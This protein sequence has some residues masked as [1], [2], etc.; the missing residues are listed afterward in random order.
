MSSESQKP[1]IFERLINPPKVTSHELHSTHV[2]MQQKFTDPTFP[3]NIF[4]L[5]GKSKPAEYRDEW[6]SFVWKRPEE[7]WP[8]QNPQV[9]Y[10]LSPTAVEQGFLGDSYF[11]SALSLLAET[12]QHLTRLLTYKVA[13]RS[14]VYGVWLHLNGRW[15]EVVVDDQFP[16]YC[17]MPPKYK[18]AFSHSTTEE[19]WV[20]LFEKAY[21]KAYGSYYAITGGSLSL[22]LGDLTGAPCEVTRLDR[23]VDVDEIWRSLVNFD[24]NGF[25]FCF[26]NRPAV[27]KDPSKQREFEAGRAFK[28][29]SGTEFQPENKPKMR[30][31]KIR[32][33]WSHKTEIEKVWPE[34][35]IR[36]SDK[37][38]EQFGELV[39]VDRSFWLPIEVAVKHFDELVVCK[40]S[41][42]GY[43]DTVFFPTIKKCNTSHLNLGEAAQIALTVSQEDLRSIKTEAP[44]YLKYCYVRLTVMEVLPN[45]FRFVRSVFGIGRNVCVIEALNK[46]NFA[47]LVELYVPPNH[48]ATSFNLEVFASTRKLLLGKVS[49]QSDEMFLDS[50]LEAWRSYMNLNLEKIPPQTRD[51]NYTVYLHKHAEAYLQIEAIKNNSSLDSKYFLD[52]ERIY[53]GAGLETN[54]REKNGSVVLHPNPQNVDLALLKHDP[55]AKENEF[56]ISGFV[57]V[58]SLS[59]ESNKHDRMHVIWLAKIQEQMTSLPKKLD[60]SEPVESKCGDS[61]SLI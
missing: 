59:K 31:V 13:T 49:D 27:G 54:P 52:Y 41:E 42:H 15:Q 28:I 22:A 61:C 56:N 30:L 45:T 46:G 16:V 37:L 32:N 8:N 6:D 36:W 47:V 10:S 24:K 26:N 14:G 38:K 25:V 19:F 3:P 43:Y 33:P 12:P 18:F 2:K 60:T 53:K 5:I 48:Q 7:V 29:V 1:E 20:Q 57:P 9:F 39:T 51:P 17:E 44:G 50:E 58:T 23:T 35:R 11:S 21:A 34:G 40:V 4:S 55:F